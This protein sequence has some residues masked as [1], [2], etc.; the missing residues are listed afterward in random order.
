MLIHCGVESGSQR[1][2]GILEEEGVNGAGEVSTLNRREKNNFHRHFKLE[3]ECEA[4][5]GILNYS[6]LI[7]LGDYTMYTFTNIVM[8][9][10]RL[11][12]KDKEFRNLQSSITSLFP[13]F[14]ICDIPRSHIH[15]SRDVVTSM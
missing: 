8:K 12:G 14:F 15:S 9:Q 4:E 1:E 5:G 11:K 2:I 7:G 13:S 10:N 3:V 6:Q